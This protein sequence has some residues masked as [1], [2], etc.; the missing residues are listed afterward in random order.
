[1][2]YSKQV[3]VKAF[4]PPVSSYLAAVGKGMLL[5]SVF[6]HPSLP[7]FLHQLAHRGF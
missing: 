7:F 2:Q 5:V 6:Y 1:M 4:A 3:Q